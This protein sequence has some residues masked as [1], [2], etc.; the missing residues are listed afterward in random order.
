MKKGC[1]LIFLLVCIL[2]ACSTNMET[3]KRK[4]EDR[5]NVAVAYMDQ[6]NY[7]EALRELIEAEKLYADDPYLQSDL[8]FVYMQKG[9]LGLAI[10]HFT[11]ALE[12]KPDFS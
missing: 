9:K 3:R 10:K 6:G 4:A 11:R 2:T 12:L 8:G 7:T 1:Y 5:R